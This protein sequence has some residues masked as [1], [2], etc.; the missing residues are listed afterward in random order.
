MMT[1]LKEHRNLEIITINLHNNLS[2]RQE[3]IKK[4]IKADKYGRIL[5]I[6][7]NEAN[8]GSLINLHN[9][10]QISNGRCTTFSNI[11]LTKLHNADVP[12]V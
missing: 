12:E 1:K 8:Q 6:M 3:I 11:K 9:I 10:Y 5:L 2:A 7:A 4:M